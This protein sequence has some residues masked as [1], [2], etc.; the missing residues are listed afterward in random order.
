[1]QKLKALIKYLLFIGI[2]IVLIWWSLHKI[3][4][5]HWNE[6]KTSLST[7][8]YWLFIP[9]LFILSLS[10]LLRTLRWRILMRPMGYTPSLSNTFCAVMI[11]YLANLALPRLGE[12]L[13]CTLLAR[14]EKVPANKLVGTIVAERAFDVLSLLTVFLLALILQ[15][16]VVIAGLSSLFGKTATDGKNSFAH[17]GIAILIALFVLVAFWWVLKRFAHVSIIQ[18]IKLGI[19][20]IIHGLTSVKYIQN[21]VPF[22]L[23]TIGIWVLY[24][25]GTWIG[26][27]ATRGTEQLGFPQACSGLVFASLGMI[28]TPGGL[29][30]YAYF[31]AMIL[32]SNGVPYPIGYAN[33]T[34]QWFAQ[35]LIVLMV[36]FSC[37][38]VLPFI[39]RNKKMV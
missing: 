19:R 29:G 27:Y 20:G 3:P 28:I 12:V 35:F 15:Y 22:F 24:L 6:F 4:D 7:A 5:N 18:K 13:K 32:T 14:Y 34:L 38:A 11:G 36:G 17:T 31:L 21:K 37:V 2:G 23:Y 16:D 8:R 30:A 26:F 10:H 39:N 9:V 1:M 25:G 33:G